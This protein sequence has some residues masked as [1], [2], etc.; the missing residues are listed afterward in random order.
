MQLLYA[1][2]SINDNSA[3]KN[4]TNT[5]D[6]NFSKTRELLVYLIYNTLQVAR[7]AEIDARNRAAKN[8]TTT[9]DLN[10]NIKIAGNIML[11]QIA[12][13]QSFIDAVSEFKTNVHTEE[14]ITRKLYLQLVETDEYQDYIATDSRDKKTDSHILRFIF[15]DILLPSDL[16]VSHA[17]DRF[18]NWDD[19]I[20]MLQIV[21]N[22]YLQ[23]TQNIEMQSL[24]DADKWNF[25]KSL[26]QTCLDKKDFLMGLIVPKLNNWDADRIASLDMIMIQMGLSELMYFETIPTKVTINEYIDLAK[27]YSTVQSGNFINGIL[28]NLHKE[29]LTQGKITK[30]DFRKR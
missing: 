16:F 20:E 12:E 29:L 15:N 25:A 8:I 10:V 17:E 14:E 7:Y 1:M 3:F 30:V 26:L 13:E 11:W 23:R 19:D 2:E 22:K 9:E 21:I 18:G 5:L 27:E 4:P 6:K 24:I 28:D